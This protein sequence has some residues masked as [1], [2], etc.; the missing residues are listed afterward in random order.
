VI[1][2][3]R[4]MLDPEQTS[5]L[6]AAAA[7]GDRGAWDRLVDEFSGLVWSVIRGCGLLGADAADVSQT[8]WLRFVEH[9]DRLRQ[10]DR[11]GAWLA[12]TARHECFRVL[13]R[14]GRQVVTAEVPEATAPDETDDVV[15]ALVAAADRSAVL[16][17]LG[18]IPVRCQE[19]LR[20]MVVEPRLTYDEIAEALEVSR[21]WIGPT[22]GRC[23]NHLRRALALGAAGKD[24]AGAMAGPRIRADERD[25]GH[26]KEAD[27]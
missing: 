22:R 15:E 23:L 19:L 25:S 21:G 11:A 7:G 24:D 3:H 17:A 2:Y 1:L 9:I 10:A 6:V 18:R 26:V 12:T 14:Q 13:R 4:P 8:V 5:Q 16:V 20:L 27:R